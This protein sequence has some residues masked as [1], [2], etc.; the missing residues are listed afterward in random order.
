MKTKPAILFASLLALLVAG[1]ASGP[2]PAVYPPIEGNWMYDYASSFTETGELPDIPQEWLSEL[3][4]D[5][6]PLRDRL[7]VLRNPPEILAI[8]RMGPRLI[9][10][11]GGRFER[12]YFVDGRAAPPGSEITFTAQ[13]IVAV[14]HEPELTLTETW[15]VSADRSTLVVAVR[16]ETTKLPKPLDIKRIYR[17][18]KSF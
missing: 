5:S 18:A 12:T 9:I 7:L 17:S 8:E 11:G 15:A 4:Q 2:P 14:H 3:K 1:C 10:N 6:D 13:S 16:A